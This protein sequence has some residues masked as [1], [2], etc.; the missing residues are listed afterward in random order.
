MKIERTSLTVT[1]DAAFQVRDI[2][3][4]VL[5]RVAAAGLRDGLVHVASRHT[6]AA[7]IVNEFEPN[8]IQDLERW[9]SEIAPAR[10]GWKHDALAHTIP[11]EPANTHAHLRAMLLGR[12]ETLA[13][14]GGSLALGTWQRL[15]FVELDGPRR[16]SLE[17]TMLGDFG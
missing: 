8:L 11:S 2:T 9:L 14:A 6:T 10:R 12:S 5:E 1:T 7:V 3:D 4:A 17:L 16:R 15:W 13:V